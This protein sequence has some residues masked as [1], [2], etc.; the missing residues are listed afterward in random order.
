MIKYIDKINPMPGS[1]FFSDREKLFYDMQSAIEDCKNNFHILNPTLKIS[2]YNGTIR[3]SFDKLRPYS[4]MRTIKLS[5]DKSRVVGE[6]DSI[7]IDDENF[8]LRY[9]YSLLFDNLPN[10]IGKSIFT[11]GEER[12][13]FLHIEDLYYITTRYT[14]PDQ[15]LDSD[16][17]KGAD[18][19]A[20]YS[21][22]SEKNDFYEFKSAY[23]LYRRVNEYERKNNIE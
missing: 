13:I 4:N 11:R 5:R 1:V 7:I 20:C 8:V 9:D 16:Y 14:H 18:I 23:R 17:R 3:E 19:C 10:L 12:P 2:S 22:Y 15:Y 21:S 6:A